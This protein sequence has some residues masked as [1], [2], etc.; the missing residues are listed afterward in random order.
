VVGASSWRWEEE[1]WDVEHLEID[2]GLGE[3]KSG[4]KNIKEYIFKIS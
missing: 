2:Q 1:V 4:L 3:I